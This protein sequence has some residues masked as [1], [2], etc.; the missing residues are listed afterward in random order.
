MPLINFNDGMNLQESC[1]Q[2]S[3]D[4]QGVDKFLR[5]EP[6][7]APQVQHESN[8]STINTALAVPY[9]DNQTPYGQ[10]ASFQ[11]NDMPPFSYQMNDNQDMLQIHK[12][13]QDVIDSHI[14]QSQD[15]NKDNPS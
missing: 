1:V 7:T 2:P 4:I 14:E 12:K 3:S 11:P 9:I 13:H 5:L 10:N 8:A 6:P 15:N